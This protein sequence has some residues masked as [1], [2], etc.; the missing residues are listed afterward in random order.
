MVFV[1]F[2]FLMLTE[3]MPEVQLT[4]LDAYLMF[5]AFLI[6]ASFGAFGTF[7]FF[8]AQEKDKE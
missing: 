6:G 5:A 2:V 7:L 3:V 1:E 4:F 8:I